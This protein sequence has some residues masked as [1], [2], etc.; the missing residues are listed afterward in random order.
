ME[1]VKMLKNDP[2]CFE[3]TFIYSASKDLNMYYCGKRIKSACHSYGPEIRTHFLVVYIK[4]GYGTLLSSPKKLRLSP[5]QIFV[6]FPNEK[7]HYKVDENSLWTISWI[8]IYGNLAYDFFEKTGLTPE[9]PLIKLNKPLITENIF[10]EIYNKSFSDKTAD[11]INVIS[12]IYK[13]F[14]LLTEGQESKYNI[15]YI[16]EAIHIIDYNY[17]KN[18]SVKSI[19][20]NLFINPSYLSRIFKKEK[21]ITLKEYI[22]HKKIN[23]AKEL[24]TYEDIPISMVSN[25]VGISDALYFSRIFKKKTGLSPNEY[26]KLNHSE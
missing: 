12:L 25:S 2:T 11:K 13:F 5:G 1:S 17:D 15:N 23:R 18:I 6:M 3:N 14:S 20:K 21:G 26:K 10:E 16:E 24:L 7:I 19:A 4:E 9:N 8:G 22:L